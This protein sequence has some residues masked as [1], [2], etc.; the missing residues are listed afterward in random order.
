MTDHDRNFPEFYVT[1]AHPC[2]YLP[3]RFE[4]K[5]FTH[6]HSDKT[7]DYIDNL[8]RNGFRRSQRIA[9]LP[10]C[11]GCRACVSVRIVTK[12]FKPSKS[13]RRVIRKNRDLVA[14]RIS[15]QT[16]EEQYELFRRYVRSRHGDGGMSDMTEA[17]YMSMVEECISETR[18]IEYRVTDGP[19]YDEAEAE[20]TG[21]YKNKLIAVVLSDTLSDGLSM[22]YS[23]FDPD[24][25]QRSIGTYLILD[26]INQVKDENKDY[27]YLGYWVN[28][29]KKMSYKTR[30]QP[31]EH[32]TGHDWEP[33]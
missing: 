10:Y 25:E 2:P 26:H 6:L 4:R 30:F 27:V 32:L 13:M 11:D 31:Q 12:D 21:L 14:T 24:L 7:V 19:D 15:A 17:D 29:C 3:D 8:L 20:K 9:Y 28:G 23:F 33:M 18:L 16:T 1:S 5:L 22:V